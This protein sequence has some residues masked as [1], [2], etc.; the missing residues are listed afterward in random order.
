MAD[1]QTASGYVVCECGNDTFIDRQRITVE[2]ETVEWS[3]EY[4]CETCGR[5]VKQEMAA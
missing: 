2:E 1:E 3:V 4:D 5:A